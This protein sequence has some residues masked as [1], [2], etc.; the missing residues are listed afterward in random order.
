[1]F[2][3]SYHNETS[4]Q[5]S[6]GSKHPDSQRVRSLVTHTPHLKTM[7]EFGE[8]SSHLRMVVNITINNKNKNN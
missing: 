6:K 7:A 1:M 4:N 5:V 8:I 3:G 2:S